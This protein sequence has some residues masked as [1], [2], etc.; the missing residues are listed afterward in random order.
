MGEAGKAGLGASCLP[1]VRLRNSPPSLLRFVPA[2]CQTLLVESLWLEVAG[3]NNLT[4][5]KWTFILGLY[6]GIW[7]GSQGQ[8]TSG[9]I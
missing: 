3:T 4:E 6:T 7:H 8:V 2:I 9:R 5:I 1:P